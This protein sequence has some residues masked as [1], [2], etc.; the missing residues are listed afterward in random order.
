VDQARRLHGARH[1]GNKTRKL[2][3][4][5]ASPE[6][7]RRPLITLGAL[8]SNQRADGGR[9][10]EARA[11]CVLV[12]EERVSQPTDAYRHNGNVLSTACSAPR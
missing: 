11:E 2:E 3:Y 9:G 4:W 8:Q 12:L 6:T 1:G 7:G 5:W 10:G